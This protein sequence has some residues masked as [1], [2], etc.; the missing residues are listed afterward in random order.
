MHCFFKTTLLF[1]LLFLLSINPSF[2]QK[3]DSF[4]TQI[5]SLIKV[6]QPQFNGVILVAKK[7][8]TAYSKV[9]GLAHME[10]KAP[11]SKNSQFEI[12]SNSKQIAAV[13]IL[14]EVEKG[15][16]DLQAPIKKY[17]PELTQ[18]WADTVTVHQLLNHTHGI[19]NYQKPLAFKPGTDFKY[20]NLS[21]VLLGKIMESV[22]GKSY[23]TIANALFQKLQMS[24]TYCYL[25]EKNQ[26][27][28]SGYINE[29]GN[30]KIVTKTQINSE[31]LAADGI[32][33]TANDLITWNN[34]LHK[35]KILKPQTYQLMTN[36]T[37][38]AQHNFFGKEKEGYGYG[39][40]IIEKEPVKYIGHT[41]LG[42]GFSCVNLYFLQSDV[43]LIILENQMNKN[44]D[45]LYASE[46]KIKNSLLKSNLL[47]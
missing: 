24:N 8:K 39:I 37:V 43:S 42:D 33:S 19:T 5:D 9:Q 21:Y 34:K 7:G 44:A 41:G 45:L 6:V 36:Y 25:K 26:H 17:L 15:N 1:S 4:T 38:K 47:K 18:S 40:R 46:I 27:L 30:F 3:Q 2:A 28:V 35:G 12:M 14:L 32:V 11:L 20:G 31:S 10:T 29:D 22:T 16:I 23:S 13:L